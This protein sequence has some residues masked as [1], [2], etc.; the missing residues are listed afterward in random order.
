MQGS[1]REEIEK[2]ADD[3]I[4]LWGT[5]GGGQQQSGDPGQGPRHQAEESSF[6]QGKER[7]KARFDEDQQ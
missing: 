6:A 1:T 2:D 4:R 3:W 5:G 7:A